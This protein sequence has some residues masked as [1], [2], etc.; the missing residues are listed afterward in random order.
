MNEL[1]FILTFLLSASAFAYEEY[2][3]WMHEL[4][5]SKWD[6]REKI[7]SVCHRLSLLLVGFAYPYGWK[8]LMFFLVIYWTL[9]DGLQNLLKDRN[10][11]A[12]SD[13]TMNPIEK[14][15]TWYIKG[16]LFLISII[17]ILY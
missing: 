10:F 17:I 9:T 8:E 1:I 11:F 7:A 6:F 15:S 13:S 16:G 2:C 4:N 5:F 14:F 3:E 12:I